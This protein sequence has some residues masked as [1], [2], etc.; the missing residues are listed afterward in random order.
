VGLSQC[1]SSF[2]ASGRSRPS[3]TSAPTFVSPSSTWHRR[4]HRLLQLS[5][6]P[7]PPSCR[8]PLH[9]SGSTPLVLHRHLGVPLAEGAANVVVAVAAMAVPLVDPSKARSC[10][11]STTHGHGSSTCGLVALAANLLTPAHHHC[12]TR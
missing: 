7:R 11:P 1:T 4:L 2:P 10:L 8:P 3:P 12:R 9:Q 6:P 5:S